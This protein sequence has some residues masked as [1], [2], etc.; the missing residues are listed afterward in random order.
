MPQAPGGG[1][2]ETKLL[3]AASQR[4][5]AAPGAEDPWQPMETTATARAPAGSAPPES[6][7]VAGRQG[8]QQT[9]RDSGTNPPPLSYA[10]RAHFQASLVAGAV[11]CGGA[12]RS[13]HGQPRDAATGMGR[14]G[15]MMRTPA[16]DTRTVDPSAAANNQWGVA[17]ARARQARSAQLARTKCRGRRASLRKGRLRARPRRARTQEPSRSK[18]EMNQ[19]SLPQDSPSGEPAACSQSHSSSSMPARSAAGAAGSGRTTAPRAAAAC[20]PAQRQARAAGQPARVAGQPARGK[21]PG[22]EGGS[23]RLQGLQ[24]RRP[25]APRRC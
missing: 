17:Q 1:A 4:S 22:G 6:G 3:P 12:Q 25:A 11:R 7:S 14:G 21:N 18:L 8:R 16:V 5:A 24:A 13:S 9:A 20:T 19:P 23:E 10:A 15:A 2:P